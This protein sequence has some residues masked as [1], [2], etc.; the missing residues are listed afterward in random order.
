MFLPLYT[1]LFVPHPHTLGIVALGKQRPQ[2]GS[3]LPTAFRE[4]TIDGGNQIGIGNVVLV[5]FFL[6]NMESVGVY[7]V[8]KRPLYAVYLAVVYGGGYHGSNLVACT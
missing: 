4:S 5:E 2:V 6:P 3:D 7:L 8:I 1:L